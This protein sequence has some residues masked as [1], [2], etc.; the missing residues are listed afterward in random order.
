MNM[1]INIY[2]LKPKITIPQIYYQFYNMVKIKLF[3]FVISNTHHF[4]L[5]YILF[6]N[7]NPAG[8]HSPLSQLV[9]VACFFSSL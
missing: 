7:D 3:V 9:I 2:N 4:F 1:C 8:L 5:L 6:Q